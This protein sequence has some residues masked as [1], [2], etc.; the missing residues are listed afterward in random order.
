MLIA[1][2]QADGGT[3]MAQAL[4]L[5]L[6]VTGN[7]EEE[8]TWMRQVVFITDGSV[9]NEEALFSLIQQRLGSSRL[10]PVGIGSAPNSHFMAKAAEYGQGNL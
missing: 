2:L 6:P 5:A 1:S 8:Q 10:F 7:A 3:E 9:G 4:T